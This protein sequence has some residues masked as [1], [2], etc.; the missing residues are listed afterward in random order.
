MHPFLATEVRGFGVAFA[1]SGVGGCW[2]GGGSV[3][4]WLE[5]PNPHHNTTCSEI[6]RRRGVY[7][8]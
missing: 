7:F 1:S 6:Q 2:V 5:G 4:Q 3:A 8:M